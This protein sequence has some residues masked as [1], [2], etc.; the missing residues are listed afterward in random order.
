M[1]AGCVALL[2]GRLCSGID[3]ILDAVRFDDMLDGAGM[4]ISGEEGSIRRAFRA[5][6]SPA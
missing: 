3:A 2:G 6:S 5:R 4:V 1:G